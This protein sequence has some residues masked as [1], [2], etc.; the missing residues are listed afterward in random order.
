MNNNTEREVELQFARNV[1]PPREAMPPVCPLNDAA[2][3]ALNG[4]TTP[5]SNQLGG[6][7]LKLQVLPEVHGT[8]RSSESRGIRLSC[9]N[10]SRGQ[11]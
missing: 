2:A 3:L 9:Y 7:K 6:I 11:Y 8:S 5:L 4:C 10:S 1:H